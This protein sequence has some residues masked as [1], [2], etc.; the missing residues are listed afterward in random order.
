MALP[1]TVVGIVASVYPPRP[2]RGVLTTVGSPLRLI[3]V[4]LTRSGSKVLSSMKS[5]YGPE[6]GER[7]FYASIN[8]GKPGSA[9]WH[10]KS[11]RAPRSLGKR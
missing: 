7:V 5:Q 2:A 8:K 11:T 10:G 4:P 3:L 1:Q 6:K 9:K